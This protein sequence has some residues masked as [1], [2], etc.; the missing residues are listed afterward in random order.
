M[1]LGAWM[2]KTFSLKPTFNRLR[3]THKDHLA[4]FPELVTNQ[5]NIMR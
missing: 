5:V 4:D 3:E 2:K 1:R